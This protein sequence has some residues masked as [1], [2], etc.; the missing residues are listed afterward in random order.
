MRY[1]EAAICIMNP[2]KCCSGPLIPNIENDLKLFFGYT[3]GHSPWQKRLSRFVGP[4]RYCSVMA[5]GRTISA[6]L[7]TPRDSLVIDVCKM[8]SDGLKN[9]IADSES[10]REFHDDWGKISKTRDAG[11]GRG[12]GKLQRDALCTR[13][14]SDKAP[15][16]N[17]NL[18]WHPLVVA[19][20]SSPKF[21]E[22]TKVGL[23]QSNG[24]KVLIFTLDEKGKK[25]ELPSESVH[26]LKTPYVVLP[27]HWE[28]LHK[29]LSDFSDED[30]TRN[31]CVIAAGEFCTEIDAIQTY[32][33]LGISIAV[34]VFGIPKS[35]VQKIAKD[36][37]EKFDEFDLY[38]KKLEKMLSGED[39]YRCPICRFELT[40][41]LEEFRDN[42]RS[43]SWKPGW[44]VDKKGEGND[45]SPQV[46]HVQPLLEAEIRHTMENVRYGHRWCNITMTDHS[47]NET[48]RFMNHVVVSHAKDSK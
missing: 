37:L 43:F 1:R 3:I 17:R 44:K 11:A 35:D 8:V 33:G 2:A 6:A 18:R 14:R 46:M 27:K 29:E 4:P 28:P 32:V 5:S 12:G 19:Q 26:E 38:N 9:L 34:T 45:N 23:T 40:H 15:F 42:T 16:S 30:W 31:S 13:G 10:K 41:N 21:Q 47:I 20:K 39:L 22:I 7:L 24:E 36:A 48:L 25:K